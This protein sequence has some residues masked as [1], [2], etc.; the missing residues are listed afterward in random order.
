[1][2]TRTK[3]I[4]LLCIVILL[5][6]ALFT[7]V[8]FEAVISNKSPET[9]DIYIDNSPIN[10]ETED[11]VVYAISFRNSMEQFSEM[12]SI[13]PQEGVVYDLIHELLECMSIAR[14][15]PYK[16]QTIAYVVDQYRN[17]IQSSMSSS[18]NVD[19]EFILSLFSINSITFTNFCS[20]FFDVTTLT[21]EEFARFLY[22]FTLRNSTQAY[23]IALNKIGQED[24]IVFIAN[25]FYLIN[26]LGD[27]KS[28]IKNISSSQMQAILYQLGDDYVEIVDKVGVDT[29]KTILGLGGQLSLDNEE[30]IRLNSYSSDMADK[31]SRLFGLLGKTAKNIENAQLDIILSIDDENATER[32]KNINIIIKKQNVCNIITKGLSEGLVYFNDLDINNI[33]AL[34]ESYKTTFGNGYRLKTELSKNEINQAYLDDIN[35]KWQNLISTINYF[36]ANNFTVEELNNLSDEKLLNIINNTNGVENMSTAIDDFVFSTLYIWSMYIINNYS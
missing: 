31:I 24:Y 21:E 17:N 22:Q 8:I 12:L 19:E 30:N 36:Q 28:D 20:D 29:L 5:V 15:P 18:I 25:T 1:M 14:I 35:T 27:I 32:E 9:L 13:N 11:N 7:M 34:L 3:N 6:V 4:I 33:E 10:Y 2:K 23:K 16:L 26:T